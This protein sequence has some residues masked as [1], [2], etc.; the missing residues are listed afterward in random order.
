MSEEPNLILGSHGTY[1]W[2]TAFSD[3]TNVDVDGLQTPKESQALIIPINLNGLLTDD[4]D[5]VV[6]IR[7]NWYR[8]SVLHLI[9]DFDFQA[10][11]ANNRY[12]IIMESTCKNNGGWNQSGTATI[13]VHERSRTVFLQSKVTGESDGVLGVETMCSPSFVFLKSSGIS[14]GFDYNDRIDEVQVH[15]ISYSTN[16]DEACIQMGVPFLLKSVTGN[17]EALIPA[18]VPPDRSSTYGWNLIYDNSDLS[19]SVF[20]LL[21][22]GLMPTDWYQGIVPIQLDTVYNLIPT[23]L[24]QDLIDALADLDAANTKL[25]ELD[26]GPGETPWS[27]LRFGQKIR[28]LLELIEGEGELNFF[29]NI[30]NELRV[31]LGVDALVA[32]IFSWFDNIFGEEA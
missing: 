23:T 5:D 10:D 11:K 1:E 9:S 25:D 7:V 22:D 30:F 14:I 12:N 17:T 24:E 28:R 27:E 26:E 6:R 20:E 2:V 21:V 29:E 8:S 18:R 15:T 3:D 32:D 4:T 16:D 13:R 31:Y 19:D